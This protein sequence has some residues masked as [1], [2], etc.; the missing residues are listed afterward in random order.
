METQMTKSVRYELSGR[1][2]LVTGAASGIGLGTAAAL[3]RAGAKVAINHLPDDPRGPEAVRSLVAE[4]HD[5]ISAPGRV[6]VPKET[7]QM[8]EMAIGML[9]GLD[10]LVNNAGTPGVKATVPVNRLDLVTDELWDNVLSTNLVGMFRC[11]K[12]AA[13]ALKA[14]HGSVVNT[15]SIAALGLA[16]SSMAYSASKAGVVNLTRNLA[17]ALA[18]EVRVNAI[19]PGAVDSTW[20]DWTEQQRK[21]QVDKSLLKKI[22]TP[23]DYADVILFLA[24][25][26][27]IITGETVVVDAGL[28]L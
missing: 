8:V 12:A 4:G 5:V 14:S 28:T 11:T 2:A 27:E 9:G 20:L 26:N 23:S 18:P 15:A 17:R 19:A 1:K 3:A 10:L 25:G 22:G 13:A 7:E 16:G 24:F 21:S 6:G